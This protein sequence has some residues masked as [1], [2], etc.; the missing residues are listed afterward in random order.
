MAVKVLKWTMLKE[1]CVT[2]YMAELPKYFEIIIVISSLRQSHSSCCK[3][4][5]KFHALHVH[6]FCHFVFHYDL[7]DDDLMGLL[8]LQ[9]SLDL[10]AVEWVRL[11][12][13]V[14]AGPHT[15]ISFRLVEGVL[16]Q[17]GN[18][19]LDFLLQELTGEMGHEPA[20]INFQMQLKHDE[21]QED[22]QRSQ[23]DID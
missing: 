19:S 14:A 4:Y 23:E 9:S 18:N 6:P 5:I 15:Q 10:T 22:Y 3:A 13:P 2:Y 17:V 16:Q 21:N 1:T 12:P 8:V 11:R 7:R 20:A